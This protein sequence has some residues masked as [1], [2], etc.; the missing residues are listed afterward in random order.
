MKIKEGYILREVAGSN[1]VVPIGN[2]QVSFNGIMTLNDV[3]T[4][5]WKLLE[6]GADK[7]QILQAVLDEYDVDSER[8]ERD[9]AIYLEKLRS[10]DLIED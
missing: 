1:I 2:A 8:A 6:N 7:Q 4:F 5:I 9:I 10:K 3:G